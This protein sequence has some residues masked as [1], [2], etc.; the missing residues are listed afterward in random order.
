MPV[1]PFWS[2]H[3]HSR[4]S[5][6]DALPRVEHIVER[7]AELEYPALG[8]TDHGNISGAVNLY[9]ACRAAGIEPLPGVELYVTPDTEMG[10]RANEH[11]TVV[12][13]SEQ[14]YRNLCK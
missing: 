14:G 12:A 13:Y 8:L 11:L 1:K 9:T 2:V 7:A 4:F 5:V 6:N 10:Q 3:T